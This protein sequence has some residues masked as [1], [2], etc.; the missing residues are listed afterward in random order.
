M[1]EVEAGARLDAGD[2]RRLREAVGWA[3]P[4]LDDATVQVALDRTWNV[5]AH[6]EDGVVGIGRLL[7]DGALYATI[8]DMIVLPAEQRRG[9]GS[10][11]LERLLE[12]AEGRTIVTLVAT[13][14]GRPLYERFGFRVES[15][16]S[17]GMIR[18]PPSETP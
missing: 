4:P 2:Y 6:S 5:V 17:W 8:W 1:A 14:A 16:G 7:D 10:A 3:T 15:G 12:R 9:I 18:R 13:E 11:I